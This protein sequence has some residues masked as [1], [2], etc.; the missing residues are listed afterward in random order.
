M[1]QA[2]TVD[3]VNWEG[4]LGHNFV[5][6]CF[7][8]DVEDLIDAAGEDLLLGSAWGHAT[9]EAELGDADEDEGD[10]EEDGLREAGW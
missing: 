2:L 6:V 4:R 5:R 10:D 3:V 9:G 7:A 1:W 8:D